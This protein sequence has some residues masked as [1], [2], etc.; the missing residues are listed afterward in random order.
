MDGANDRLSLV[1]QLAQRVN[2]GHG[3]ERVQPTGRLITEQQIRVVYHGAGKGQA[4]TLT[5]RNALDALGRQADHCVLA[6]LQ[7][8]VEHDLLTDIEVLY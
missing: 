7:I 2:N 1:R 5:T 3:H 8:Q 4:A 6:L